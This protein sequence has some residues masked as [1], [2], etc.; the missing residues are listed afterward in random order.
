MHSDD[1]HIDFHGN[2]P[3]KIGPRI[4]SNP[5]RTQIY[6]HTYRGKI[7]SYSFRRIKGLSKY[8]LEA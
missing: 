6:V 4:F 8:I 7:I 1:D 5:L 3:E 2:R